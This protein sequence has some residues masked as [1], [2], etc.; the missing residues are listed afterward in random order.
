MWHVW[1]WRYES[2]AFAQHYSTR[3]PLVHTHRRPPSGDTLASLASI[4][5]AA[6]DRF[7]PVSGGPDDIYT[8]WDDA[9]S[10]TEPLTV[11]FLER[12]QSHLQ[13]TGRN[14]T[15]QADLQ[16][17]INQF[18]EIARDVL[19]YLRYHRSQ[20][21]LVLLR[22]YAQQQSFTVSDVD[23]DLLQSEVERLLDLDQLGRWYGRVAQK[24]HGG[25]TT[26]PA[27]GLQG[28]QV[29]AAEGREDGK[30]GMGC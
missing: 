25:L 2:P 14:T 22:Q 15:S 23:P 27:V 18:K 9:D 12:L 24:D 1:I 17:V 7:R 4:Y 8:W 5:T 11:A 16:K 29:S 19:N 30:Q 3:Q 10:I 13:A 20:G 26:W 21:L 6:T 28:N